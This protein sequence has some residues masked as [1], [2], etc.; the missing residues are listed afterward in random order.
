MNEVK[1]K[2]ANSKKKKKK[3]KLA[4]EGRLQFI[5]M[6]TVIEL[7]ACQTVNGLLETIGV[8]SEAKCNETILSLEYY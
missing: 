7:E 4:R 3:N 2:S 5:Q 8:K 1:Q 6:L